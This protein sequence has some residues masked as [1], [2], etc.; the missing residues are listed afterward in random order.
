MKTL[1]FI[2]H[3]K[4][5]WDNAELDD[6]DRPL[7][8][9]G[10]EDAPFMA[11]FLAGKMKAPDKIVSSPANRAFSTAKHFAQAFKIEPD[12]ILL[13]KNIYEASSGQLMQVVRSLND[14]WNTVL[15]L[16]HNPS[17]TDVV[18]QLSPKTVIFNIPTCGIC[19]IETTAAS[20]SEISHHNSKMV[21][22]FFPKEYH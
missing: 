21:H 2:R 12:E 20:W 10:R 17:F 7:N 3:A 13:D 14:E 11:A 1:I 8:A 6:F 16:G 5:S 18:N 15:I 9:R 22:H 4:S 19:Q